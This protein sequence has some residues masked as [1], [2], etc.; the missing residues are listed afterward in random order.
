MYRTRGSGVGDYGP[1]YD[2]S[3]CYMPLSQVEAD[4]FQSIR[5]GLL[6]IGMSVFGLPVCEGQTLVQ[7]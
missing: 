6:A 7:A 4:S 1:R 5:V 2:T 3:V